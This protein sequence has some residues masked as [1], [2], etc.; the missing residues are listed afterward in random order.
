[1]E[2]RVAKKKSDAAMVAEMEAALKGSDETPLDPSDYLS[3]GS[4]VLNQACSGRTNGGL[5]KGLY[6]LF[7][8]DTNTGKTTVTMTL[9]AEAAHSEAFTDHELLHVNSEHGANMDVV[10]HFGKATAD[11]IEE[12]NPRTLEEFYD[13][14]DAKLDAGVPFIAVLDSMDALIPAAA[15][16]RHRAGR[17]ARDKGD[18]EKGSF[19]T[20]KPKI[21][22]DRLRAVSSRLKETGSILIIISQTRQ[23]IGWGSQYDPRTFSGGDALTFYARLQIWTKLKMNLKK[24]VKGVD[25]LIGKD[26]EVKVKKNHITGW[27]GKLLLRLYKLLIDDVGGM[28]LWL[29]E[30]GHWKEVRAKASPPG[31]GK[32][33]APE[34]S[35]SGPVE[36]LVLKIE[37]GNKE[38]KLRKVVRKVWREI[39]RLSKPQ[40]KRK[41]T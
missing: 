32:V 9:F 22:S 31:T 40:R 2:D 39:E 3:T 27:E 29:I 18:D 35:F 15:L 5:R 4:S 10:K 41:Y 16:K 28:I 37:E 23:R 11:R 38:G 21:N 25:R 13:Y 20:E 8:G 14:M 19:A 24:K 12:T 1:L 36:K 34:F 7:V 26:I 6:Y 33:T 30:E 17:K